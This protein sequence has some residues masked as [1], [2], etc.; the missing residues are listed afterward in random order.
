[1]SM[2]GVIDFARLAFVVLTAGLAFAII[3]IIR[4]RESSHRL[5]KPPGPKP[6]PVIGNLLDMPRKQEWETFSE[7]AT[8]YGMSQ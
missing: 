4:G 3:W 6:W 8:T 7:W 5:P 2:V 1:M